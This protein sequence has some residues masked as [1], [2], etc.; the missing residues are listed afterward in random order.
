MKFV[1]SQRVQVVSV[2]VLMFIAGF[3]VSATVKKYQV[4]GPVLDVSDSMIVV[5]KTGDRWELERNADTKITGQL[6]TGAKVTIQYRMV[7]TDVDV[8]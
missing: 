4:T 1:L 5:D 7:A 2:A 6:K 8:K 3:F